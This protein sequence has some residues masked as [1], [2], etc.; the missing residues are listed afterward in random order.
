M[1]DDSQMVNTIIEQVHP[2][3]TILNQNA[4]LSYIIINIYIIH[5]LYI[6]DPCIHH[7]S[8]HIYDISSLYTHMIYHLSILI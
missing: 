6:H 5:D 1:E 4:L 8:I 2:L 7:L 3:Y